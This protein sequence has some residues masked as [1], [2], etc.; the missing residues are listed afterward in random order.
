MLCARCRKE[1]LG[2]AHEFVNEETEMVF[3]FHQKCWGL[4]HFE[5]SYVV[6]TA[7][8]RAKCD[9]LSNAL[10]VSKRSG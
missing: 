4:V 8:R 3:Y 10:V 2:D 6:Y 9:T 1:I 5:A 7:I